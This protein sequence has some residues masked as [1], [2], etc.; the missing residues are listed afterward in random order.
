[1]KKAKRQTSKKIFCNA[2]PDYYLW[3]GSR[4]GFGAERL[5]NSCTAT[6]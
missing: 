1:M 6:V 2:V 4:P 5:K 3:I